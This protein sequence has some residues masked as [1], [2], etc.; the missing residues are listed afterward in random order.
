MRRRWAVTLLAGSMAILGAGAGAVADG[1]FGGGVQQEAAARQGGGAGTPSPVLAAQAAKVLAAARAALGG[2]AR[3]ASVKAFA[4]TG[5]TRQVRGEHLVPIEFEILCELPDKYARTDEIP[6]QESGPTTTGFSGADP[7]QI[8]PPPAPPADAARQARVAAARADLV[9]LMLGMFAGAPIDYPLTF[10]Y[11]GQAEAPQGKA[12]AVD[13]SGPAGF[14]ARLFINSETHLPIM[15]SWQA[16]R[17][18]GPALENRL[19][20]SDYRDVD[21]LQW[22]FRV[23]RAAGA[24]TVEETTFDRFRLNPKIDPKKFALRR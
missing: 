11:A 23:R 20:Y 7:I 22:P 12:D 24:E 17:P 18:R 16:A 1:G 6:A 9:R 14:T 8:P 13:V 10:A 5:R 15:V 3:L 19:Y 4:A 2:D 21:G